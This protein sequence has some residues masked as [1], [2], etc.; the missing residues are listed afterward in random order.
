MIRLVALT[1]LLLTACTATPFIPLHEKQRGLSYASARPPRHYGGEGS[2]ASLRKAQA[3]GVNW[4]SVTPFG[5]HRGTPE[6]RWGGPNVWESDASLVAVTKEAHALGLR[7]LLKPHVWSRNEPAAEQWSDEEWRRY[8]GDYERFITHYA[9][10]ARD[11]GADA[12][13]VGN[14]QKLASR[15]EP[16]WRRIIASVRAIYKGPLTYGANFDEV[17]HVRFWDAL[18]WIGVSAYFPLVDAPKPS[19][20]ELVRAWQPVVARL[21]QLARD[22]RKPIVFTEI[23]YRSA[24]GAAWRQWELPR[25]A[26]LALDVQA[27][28]YEAFFEA[29]WPQPWLA[30]V[31]PW[32]WFSYPEHSGPQSNDYELENKP[33]EAVVREHYSRSA[34]RSS[35]RR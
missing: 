16:E 1:A 12:L 19:R 21:A 4:I 11:T 29:V 30:G 22:E 20:E 2:A 31:Y 8:L 28:A 17:F 7:V 18:D 24:E 15:F 34:T 9:T 27:T 14:E 3:L 26:P 33:A 5:F 25:T 13:S 10:I 23:G 35:T 6:L 32:K